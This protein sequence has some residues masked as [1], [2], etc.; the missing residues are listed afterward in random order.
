MR[1]P[2]TKSPQ[3][4]KA[5]P[6]LSSVV[7]CFSASAMYLTPTELIP[8]RCNSS[9]TRVVLVARALAMAVAP[10]SSI[11]FDARSRCWIV[12]LDTSISAILMHPSVPSPDSARKAGD[13]DRC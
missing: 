10:W 4:L 2:L 6:K 9:L 8:F 12:E 3:P 5:N 13:R 7:L 11:A 1:M